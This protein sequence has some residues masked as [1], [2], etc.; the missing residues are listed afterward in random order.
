MPVRA[1]PPLLAQDT[2]RVLGELLGMD[3]RTIADLKQGGVR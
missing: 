3:A 1:A 2:A